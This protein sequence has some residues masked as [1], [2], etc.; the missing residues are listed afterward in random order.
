MPPASPFWKPPPVAGPFAR[1]LLDERIAY[2][3]AMRRV[4]DTAAGIA[5]MPPGPDRA[6]A[7]TAFRD[8][9]KEDADRCTLLQSIFTPDFAGIFGSLVLEPGDDL[10]LLHAAAAVA[11]WHRDHGTLPPTLDGLLPGD[12]SPPPIYEPSPDNRSFL[13][14]PPF[15]F[16]K[17]TPIRFFLSP[18]TAPPAPS[19]P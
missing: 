11:A 7:Y 3:E 12:L 14:G 1:W 6:D 16:K 8:R 4:L 9:L 5:A 19:L 15:L 13:L 18:P 10:L 17:S 2:A